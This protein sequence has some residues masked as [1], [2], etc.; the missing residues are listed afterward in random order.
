MINTIVVNV[1]IVIVIISIVI[2][3]IIMEMKFDYYGLFPKLSRDWA[4]SG[5]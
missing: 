5:T 1:I 2:N 3:I 4:N